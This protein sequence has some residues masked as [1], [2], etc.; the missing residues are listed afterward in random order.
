MQENEFKKLLD[1]Y[2]D[3]TISDHELKLLEKFKDDVNLANLEPHFKSKAHKKAVKDALWTSI[4]SQTQDDSRKRAAIWK[5]SAA[6]AAF[7]ALLATAYLL[8]QNTA[9]ETDMI[10]PENAITL[11][12]ENGDIQV[13]SEDGEVEVLD[14]DGNV[15]GKQDGESIKYSEVSS[16]REL[17]Y[18]TLTVPQGKT[19][20]LQLSD[21]TIAYLNAG[22]SIK[23]PVQFMEGAQRQI[24][25]QGEAFLDVAKDPNHPFVVNTNGLNVRVLGTQFNVSAYPEDETTEVVLVEGA[26]SLYTEEDGYGSEKNVKLEPGF[27]G[28]FDKTSNHIDTSKVITSLYTSWINGKL[29][30]RNMTF[31]NI[32]KK[33]ER[34]YDVTIVNNN[35]DLTHDLFNANFGKEPIENVLMELKANYGI[36]YQILDEKIIID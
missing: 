34:H 21:G 7:L 36:D 31:S 10:I 25:V 27:K 14:K 24:Y 28:S 3:G 16:K 1:K 22:S 19:F 23:Y 17:A 13:I 9:Q 12:L 32:M 4:H 33:L 18:N 35:K 15:I 2:L 20:Q 26:V 30:F 6:A 29:V 11:Q 8:L 5:I